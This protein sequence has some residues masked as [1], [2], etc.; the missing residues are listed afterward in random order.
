MMC[1]H[2]AERITIKVLRND[3][4]EIWRRSIPLKKAD[5]PLALVGSPDVQAEGGDVARIA[6][7]S[8]RYA[9]KDVFVAECF[10]RNG[11]RPRAFTV[12]NQV[13]NGAT[14]ILIEEEDIPRRSLERFNLWA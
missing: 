4:V 8:S 5:E 10:E 2:I 12:E 6:E 3:L 14:P 13:V 9:A 7:C 11:G 1:D